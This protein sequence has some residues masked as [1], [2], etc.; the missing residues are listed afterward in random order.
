VDPGSFAAS[1]P[2]TAVY[3]THANYRSRIAE[4]GRPVPSEPSYFLKPLAALSRGGPVVRPAGTAYLCFEGE[5][6]LLVGR[7]LRDVDEA[8]AA[9]AVIGMAAANDLGLHDLVHVDAGSLL[10]DKG[11][12]GFCPVGD[13]VD[14]LDGTTTLST[15]VDGVTVQSATLDEMLFAPGYLLADLARFTTLRPGDVVLTGTPAGSRP[16]VPGQTVTVRLGDRSAVSSS[17][18]AGPV[19]AFGGGAPAVDTA[20]A[21]LLALAEHPEPSGAS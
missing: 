1:H 14:P 17:I 19:P 6:A 2:P 10:R 12:D 11:H 15:E 20:Q 4:L 9:A 8:T 16:L 7:S 5:M 21:R 13:W 18:V 3:C